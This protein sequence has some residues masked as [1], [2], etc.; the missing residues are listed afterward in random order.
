V[1]VGSSLLESTVATLSTQLSAQQ[2]NRNMSSL[3]QILLVLCCMYEFKIIDSKII[4]DLLN[5]LVELRQPSSSSSS[6]SSSVGDTSLTDDAISLITLVLHNAG[7]N[8]RA[9]NPGT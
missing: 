4:F 5:M 8:L 1:S 7:F 6:S 3:S 9:G 2:T